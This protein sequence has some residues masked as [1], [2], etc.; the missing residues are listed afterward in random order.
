M[1][2]S[3]DIQLELSGIDYVKNDYPDKL[4]VHKMNVKMINSGVSWRK[5]KK[6]NRKIGDKQLFLHSIQK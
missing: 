3:R 4:W 5:L 6:K 2:L 1:I